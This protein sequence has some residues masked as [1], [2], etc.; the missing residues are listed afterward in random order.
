[1]H[2]SLHSAAEHQLFK[3]MPMSTKPNAH[4]TEYIV[5]CYS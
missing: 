1:M 3:L 4:L 2:D 5:V